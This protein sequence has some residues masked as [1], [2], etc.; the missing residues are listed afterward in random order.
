MNDAPPPKLRPLNVISAAWSAGFWISR[1]EEAYLNRSKK[2][3]APH[4][5]KGR[6]K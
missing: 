4:K 6:R 1:E 5:P 2:K 3:P